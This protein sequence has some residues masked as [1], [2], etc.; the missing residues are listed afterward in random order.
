MI[1]TSSRSRSVM[2]AL[3]R[4]SLAAAFIDVSGV[5]N[6]WASASSTVARKLAALLRRLGP[7]RRFP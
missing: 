7:G 3:V 6:S 2:D 1:D 5:L 4:R